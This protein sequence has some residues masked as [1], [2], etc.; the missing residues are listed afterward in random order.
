MNWHTT[1][2]T[3]IDVEA[4]GFGP[5]SYPLEVGFVKGDGPRYC[6]LIQPRADWNHWD[7][8]AAGIHGIRR[9]DLVRLGKPVVQVA[10]ELN[11]HLDGETVYS[12]GWVVDKPWLIR[13]Y[14]AGGQV[15]QFTISPLEM[16]LTEHQ[17]QHW[18]ETKTT[19]INELGGLSRHR[20]S[21]DAEVIQETWRRT[22]HGTPIIAG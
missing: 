2:P 6:A 13:L 8:E 11:Q 5:F 14:E 1:D 17:M 9:E 10:S 18:H 4:S 19:V 22:R 15:M 21:V 16:I 12:D 7:E 3:I 20:A